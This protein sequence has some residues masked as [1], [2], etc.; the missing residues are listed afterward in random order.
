MKARRMLPILAAVLLVA[1]VVLLAFR[2]GWFDTA[3]A[4]V[5]LLAVL[6]VVA[7][8]AFIFASN[9]RHHE[10]QTPSAKEVPK[11]DRKP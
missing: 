1:A 7:I 4:P 11:E 9:H 5:I 6:A 2:F 3:T 8:A 10:A